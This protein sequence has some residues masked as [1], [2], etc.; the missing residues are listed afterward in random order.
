MF[1]VPSEMLLD[2]ELLGD[3]ESAIRSKTGPA[4]KN[5]FQVGWEQAL[6]T[7]L[8]LSTLQLMLNGFFVTRKVSYRVCEVGTISVVIY[9]L[10]GQ[11]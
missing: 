4:R 3:A 7:T 8:D 5:L 10:P 2:D 11:G 6:S 9:E 1:N